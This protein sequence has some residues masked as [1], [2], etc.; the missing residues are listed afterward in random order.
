MQFLVSGS[1]FWPTTFCREGKKHL[2]IGIFAFADAGNETRAACAALHYTT[3]EISSDCHSLELPTDSY[4]V[5]F[6]CFLGPLSSER[7]HSRLRARRVLVL[8]DLFQADEEQGGPGHS[9]DHHGFK[10][11]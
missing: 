4:Q 1:I 8:Q 10:V 11:N 7:L 9:V 5:S 6:L 3:T 2:N